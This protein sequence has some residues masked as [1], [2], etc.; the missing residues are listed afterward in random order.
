MGSAWGQPRQMSI[1]G[2][3]AERGASFSEL[4]TT[5]AAVTGMANGKRRQGTGDRRQETGDRRQG[6]GDRRQVGRGGPPRRL[7][8]GREGGDERREGGD[9]RRE[10]GGRGMR[11]KVI[12]Y[13]LEVIG[14]EG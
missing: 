1:E 13:T 10:G 6:S 8:R 2:V 3:E 9:A 4:G 11:K 5:G 7:V 12:G 14:E